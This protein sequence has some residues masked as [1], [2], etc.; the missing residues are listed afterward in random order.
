MPRSIARLAVPLAL[1]ALLA[2]CALSRRTTVAE[3]K[4]NPGRYQDRT[5]AIDGVVTSSW[6]VPL[7]PFRLYRVNDGTGELTVMS[8]GG[9]TPTKGAHVRVKGRVNEF[10]TFGG[11][12]VGLHL[13]ETDLDFKR[14]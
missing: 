13:Q 6:A 5:V 12:S 2:G 3:L 10:A 8:R 1:A 14:R 4:Y 11:Q 9:R 7:V